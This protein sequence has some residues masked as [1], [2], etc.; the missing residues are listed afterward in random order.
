MFINVSQ[1]KIVV[2]SNHHYYLLAT[3]EDVIDIG[4]LDYEWQISGAI[5]KLENFVKSF[6]L[7]K[8][9]LNDDISTKVCPEANLEL[10]ECI[11]S[12]T[13]DNV[14]AFYEECLAY[15]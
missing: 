3:S 13:N 12:T 1:T 7:F 4:D 14:E 10:Y 8:I 5:D 6:K 2:F 15:M 11:Q 9:G